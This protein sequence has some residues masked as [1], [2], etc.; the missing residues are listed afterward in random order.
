MPLGE[1]MCLAFNKL[2]P[3]KEY[4]DYYVEIKQPI[5][6]D[7]IKG[8]I[9]RNLYKSVSDFVADVDLMCNNAQ[10]YN[11]PASYIYDVAGDIRTNLHRLAADALKRESKDAPS[12]AAASTPASKGSTPLLKLKIR[13]PAAPEQSAAPSGEGSI[14]SATASYNTASTSTPKRKRSKGSAISNEAAAAAAAAISSTLGAGSAKDKQPQNGALSSEMNKNIDDLFQAIY[15]ADLGEALKLL[16]TPGLPLNEYRKVV[17]KDQDVISD[18]ETN[19]SYT[20]AP[21]HAAACYGRLKVAQVLCEKGANIE[22]VDTMHRSTPLAWAAY[23]GRKRLAKCLVRVYKADV[24][25]R[26]AHD[27]LP[28]Q[29]VLDPQNPKWAE[30]LMPTDGSK[31][32]LPPPEEK[33]SSPEAKKTPSKR[34]KARASEDL[35]AQPQ[36]PSGGVSMPATAA[37]LSAM[38]QQASAGLSAMSVSAPLVPGPSSSQQSPAP[39]ISSSGPAIPQCIGGIGHQE[40]VHP[41]MADA[42]K[43]IVARVVDY[44]DNEENRL[45]E[46]F[47]DLPDREEYPEYYEVIVHPMALNLVKARIAAGY[48]SFDAF[49]YDMTW[50]FN[51]ATFFNESDSQIYQDAVV[52]EGEYKRICRETVK[53]YN[54][55]FDTS[56]N[57]AV[58]PEGRYVSRVTAGD[59][60]VF[61][62]DFIYVRSGTEMRIAMVTRLRVGGAY[63]R[64]KFI[65]GRWL[66]KPSEIPE[67]AGQLVYPHQLFAGPEFDSHGVRGIS[68]K[69]FVL[70]P[71]VYSR[72]Y[73]Q[74]YA[75]QD[76]FICES[77]YEKPQDGPQPGVFKPITNWAHCFKTPLMRPPTFISY[78]MPF[79][80]IKRP[81]EVWNN[82]NFLPHMGMTMLNRDAA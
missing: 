48:R 36:T 25:A 61:V 22:A 73:P 32:D 56:Y 67:L 47:E 53:K 5:A 19:D 62:G 21:L 26:N 45:A 69:C 13:Q 68:G 55:P 2:P 28:I 3:K 33:E 18:T 4:P 42:M 12:V 54:I 39:A 49:N 59:H 34:A 35:S 81:V 37:T 52:L 31:V 64:R 77:I 30:F 40:V 75:A 24:N 76:I 29:I 78:I 66:L 57:D 16:D 71:N 15:D 41:Q 8:R 38:V 27:Q 9:T 10:Q 43:E 46:V 6:L 80:P 20:W 50:I 79:S 70:L 63:D 7:I 72:V 23:T 74:G 17:L 11:M 51:N 82:T 65:D 14:G 44:T 58:A 60:D 1:L